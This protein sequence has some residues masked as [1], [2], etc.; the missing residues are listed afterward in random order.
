MGHGKGLPNECQR[1]DNT[2]W[3]RRGQRKALSV[4]VRPCPAPHRHPLGLTHHHGAGGIVQEIQV[5]SHCQQNDGDSVLGQHGPARGWLLQTCQAP[6]SGPRAQGTG[7]GGSGGHRDAP[8]TSGILRSFRSSMLVA[9]EKRC[10]PV[11]MATPVP[12]SVW[13]TF[14][15]S[16][17]F[18]STSCGTGTQLAGGHQRRAQPHA[19]LLG[20]AP[21]SDRPH[22][23]MI[24]APGS[25]KGSLPKGPRG[26]GSG[27]R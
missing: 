26:L 25:T 27:P 21:S 8:G 2:P 11:R 1:M 20:G 14:A 18:C 3:G 22:H 23:G 17:W 24:L 10:A 4:S 15:S 12:Y 9:R 19:V 13:K 6:A 5:L 16:T 7:G